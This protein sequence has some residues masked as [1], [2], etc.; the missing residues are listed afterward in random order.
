MGSLWEDLQKQA[1]KAPAASST[2]VSWG[3]Q[4]PPTSPPYRG[5]TPP[6]T[7]GAASPAAPRSIDPRLTFTNDPT[8]RPWAYMP[9]DQSGYVEEWRPPTF[10]Q[11]L[12]DLGLRMVENMIAAAAYEVAAFFTR[13]RFVGKDTLNGR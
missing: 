3:Q 9:R 13:R 12:K 4:T 5:A 6:S 2:G 1:G 10:W 8:D 7:S 11:I